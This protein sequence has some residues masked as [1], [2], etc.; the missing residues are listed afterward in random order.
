[1]GVRK[2]WNR[3]LTLLQDE[4]E[5]IG[6]FSG[7]H[8]EREFDWKV[9]LVADPF[10]NRYLIDARIKISIE[11]SIQGVPVVL[12]GRVVFDL[13]IRPTNGSCSIIPIHPENGSL[14]VPS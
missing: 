10:S 3:N 11:R 14:D 9:S 2:F 1:M 8:V 13:Q 12:V 7:A 5:G 6:L 4:V